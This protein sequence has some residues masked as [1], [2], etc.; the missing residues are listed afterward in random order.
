M[1][2]QSPVSNIQPQSNGNSADAKKVIFD[3]DEEKSTQMSPDTRLKEAGSVPMTPE[4]RVK[5]M[6][7]T[8]GELELALKQ[9]DEE[10]AEIKNLYEKSAAQIQQLQD[11]G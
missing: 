1:V 6:E 4:L 7:I 2:P 10:S 5:E 9:K 11:V 8:I 3:S